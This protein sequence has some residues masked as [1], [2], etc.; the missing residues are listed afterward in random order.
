M[1]EAEAH[2]APGATRREAR[3]T[4]PCAGSPASGYLSTALAAP[5]PRLATPLGG[6][7]PSRLVSGPASSIF[8]AAIGSLW[9]VTG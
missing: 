7:A 3:P 8:S 1:G 5:R 6:M 9:L 2:T 4:M